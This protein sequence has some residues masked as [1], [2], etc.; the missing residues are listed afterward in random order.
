MSITGQ[1]RWRALLFCSI[2][3]GRILYWQIQFTD[4]DADADNTEMD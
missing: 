1:G 4:V 2:S 3:D